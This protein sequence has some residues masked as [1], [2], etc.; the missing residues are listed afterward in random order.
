[1]KR[2]E[3]IE[4]LVALMC[5]AAVVGPQASASAQTGALVQWG[6][7]NESQNAGLPGGVF[8]RISAGFLHNLA[9]RPDGS[10]VQW[11][12]TS[13]G[14]A[15]NMPTGAF[16]AVAAGAFHNLA[17]RSDGTL[18]QW[19]DT[20]ANQANNMPTGGFVA[21]AA[22][23]YHNLALRSDGTLV[24]WGDVSSGQANNMP[25][26]TFAAVASGGYHNLALRSDGTLVQWGN[27]AD[28]QAD[29]MP[30]GTFAAIVAGGL[31]NLGLRTTGLPLGSGFTYQ[32]RLRQNGAPASGNANLAFALFTAP[33]G[34]SQIGTT[35]ALAGVPVTGGLFTVPLDFGA[36]ALDGSRRWLEVTANGQPLT[37]RQELTAAPYASFASTAHYASYAAYAGTTGP[38]WTVSGAALTYAGGN[39]GIGTSSPVARLDVRSGNDS[40]FRINETWG[41]IHTNGGADG[42]LGIYNEGVS[43]GRTAI[44]TSAGERFAVTNAGDVGIGV[45]SPAYR[46]HVDGNVYATGDVG[47]SCGVLSCSDA[48]FKT[49]VQ[50]MGSALQTVEKLRAV[51][52]DWRRK[53]FP[54]H[55]FSDNRQIGFIA[56]EVERILPE[57][58]SKG[59]DGT[60]SVDYGRVTPVL[61]AAIKE[62]KAQLDAD[63]RQIAE[64]DRQ[65]AAQAEEIRRHQHEIE[66]LQNRVKSLEDIERR[67]AIF[68]AIV[69]QSATIQSASKEGAQ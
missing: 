40:Y 57:V 41:D 32:G 34:G 46:L 53:E 18:V 47:A 9:L 38:G 62:L 12:D 60:Y 37:P 66:S 5:C 3:R 23:L 30:T 8:T 50:P 54:D 64:K 21:I 24:Q 26:G 1:M 20:S 19:G 10:L 7:T 2:R 55:R 36:G 15:N 43:T 58:V 69:R 63:R 49:N 42:V 35:L 28:G 14:Q 61:V 44:L 29:N 45:V 22:G 59:S 52:F 17:L 6:R 56:Q 4:R 11:G 25:M 31:H 13:E 16:T 27:T 39:V 65:I 33:T 48:R 67:L 68:E 51:R